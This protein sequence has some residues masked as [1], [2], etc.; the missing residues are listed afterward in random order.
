[1]PYIALK[2][3]RFDRAYIIGERIP[4]S[5]VDP[6]RA[7]GLAAMGLIRA[8][9]EEQPAEEQPQEAPQA[10]AEAAGD[11]AGGNTTGP[12]EEAAETDVSA[13]AAKKKGKK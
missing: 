8:V 7:E 9:P 2:P 6:S 4:D 10:A 5:V 11:D 3:T 12:V 1:M 13:Q